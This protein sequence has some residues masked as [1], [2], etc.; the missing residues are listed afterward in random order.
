MQD[1]LYET[2]NYSA[3]SSLLIKQLY[4]LPNVRL[5]TKYNSDKEY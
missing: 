5:A 3:T 1:F 2:L 4:Q